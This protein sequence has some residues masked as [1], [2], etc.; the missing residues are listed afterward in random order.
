MGKTKCDNDAVVKVMNSGR[1]QDQFLGACA[2]NIWFHSALLD[3]DIK[4]VHVL[5]S[6][7]Q[8][9][10][11]LSRWTGS[12]QDQNQ[13]CNLVERPI[14]LEVLPQMLFVDFTM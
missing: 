12:I 9:A 8:T 10:D 1:T 3:I 5:G 11:L 7:N 14:S 2:R 6:Q 4:Y 13:L